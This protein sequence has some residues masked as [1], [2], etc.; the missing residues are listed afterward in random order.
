MRNL[1]ILGLC[2]LLFT[3]AFAQVSSDKGK[4][5]DEIQIKVHRIELLLQILPVGLTKEQLNTILPKL[6]KIRAEQRKIMASEDD[7]LAK[8]EAK[9]DTTLKNGMEKGVYPPQDALVEIRKVGA[10]L[11]IRRNLVLSEMTDELYTEMKK[12][13]NAGQ[14][15]VMAKTI[16]AKAIDPKKPEDVKDEPRIKAFIRAFILDPAAYEI[17]VK[18]SEKPE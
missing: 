1:F 10:A 5:S 18:L 7:E 9:V 12:T 4:R 3:G 17:L 13:L 11:A 2:A 15:A 16:E 8:I 6:E 14:L